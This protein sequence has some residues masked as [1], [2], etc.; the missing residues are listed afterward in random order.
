MR[1]RVRGRAGARGG[2]KIGAVVG[3]GEEDNKGAPHGQGG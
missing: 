3:D 1:R 2:I